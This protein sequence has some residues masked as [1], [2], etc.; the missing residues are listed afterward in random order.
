MPFRVVHSRRVSLRRFLCKRRCCSFIFSAWVARPGK[1]TAEG[2][3]LLTTRRKD[4]GWSGR[5]DWEDN[6][7]WLDERCAATCASQWPT[8]TSISSN[9]FA[10]NCSVHLWENTNVANVQTSHGP[11]TNSK[12]ISSVGSSSV[13]LIGKGIDRVPGCY[14]VIAVQWYWECIPVS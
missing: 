5:I 6:T 11:V 12:K 9:S 14:G 7:C 8:D 1:E 10:R 4:V 3:K 13:R 2:W